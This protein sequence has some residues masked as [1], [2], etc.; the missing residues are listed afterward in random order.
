MKISSF[1]MFLAVFWAFLIVSCGGNRKESQSNLMLAA[2]DAKQ[3]A[4][5]LYGDEVKVLASGDL[6]ANGKP[7]GIAAVVRKQ[8][9]NSFWI[10]RGSFIQKDGADWKVILKMEEKLVSRSGELTNQ[11][12]ADN[13]YIISLDTAAKPVSINIVMANEY[14]KAASDDAVIKWDAKKNDFLFLPPVEDN[15]AQ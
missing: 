11:V 3:F 8:T 15:T 12:P 7:S 14:G 4:L 2:D 13:G 10:Q 6:L 9:G 1:L 5:K